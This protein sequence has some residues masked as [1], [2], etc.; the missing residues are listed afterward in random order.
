MRG[1]VYIINGKKFF[2]MGGAESVD[3]EWR[4][5]GISWWKEEMPNQAEYD[6]ALTNLENNN[7]EVDYII[8]HDCSSKFK[9]IALKDYLTYKSN[10][11]LNAFFDNI[12]DIV[13]YKH[14]YFGH[15]HDDLNLD[16]KH[17]LLYDTIIKI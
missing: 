3:K 9:M 15:Y 2:T 6:E 16:E 1:Q 14:W 11:N 13:K 12:E 17:T 4:I 10:N 5:D 7:Y 8:T